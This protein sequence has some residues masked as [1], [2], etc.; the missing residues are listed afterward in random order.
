MGFKRVAWIVLPLGP[1]VLADEPRM[2]GLLLAPFRTGDTE[3]FA[4]DLGTGDAR[5]QTRS[6]KS[7]GATPPGRPT[8]RRQRSMHRQAA[9]LGGGNDDSDPH[10]IE[11]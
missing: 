10:V 4:V 1:A 5:S 9:G 11:P 3:I 6:P 8:D 7:S 2:T